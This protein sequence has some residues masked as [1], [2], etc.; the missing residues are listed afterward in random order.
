ML[1]VDLSNNNPLVP[2]DKVKA[3][4]IRGMWHKVGEGHSTRNNLFTDKYWPGRRDYGRKIG[5][6]VGGY[7]FARPRGDVIE[8]A[9]HFAE[10]L[11][12]IGR[13]DLVPVLDFE[14]ADGRSAG[15]LVGWARRFNHEF[16]RLTGIWPLFYSYPSF[17]Q[18]LHADKVIGRGLWL[19]SY[20]PND[21]RRHP[22]TV[23]KPFKRALVH[24]Y[25]SN[26]RIPGTVNMRVDLSYSPRLVPIL[27]RGWKGWL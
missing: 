23:P 5:L 15:E 12:P 10:K 1:I 4:G 3:A 22:Y 6:R 27:A 17:I 13:K 24:Q 16:H 2:L 14:V 26:G 7:Y 19:A 25:T 9:R 21:G 8:Q 11:G 18:G 20:G